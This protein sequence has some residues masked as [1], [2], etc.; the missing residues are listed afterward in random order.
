MLTIGIFMSICY[1]ILAHSDLLLV[2]EQIKMLDSPSSCFLIHIDAKSRE[3]LPDYVLTKENV[4]FADERFDIVW[5]DIS[6]VEAVMKCACQALKNF[7]EADY[8]ILLSGNCFPVKTADYIC[9]YIHDSGFANFITSFRIPSDDCAWLEGG[10]RRL[11]CYAVRVNQRDIATIEP[12][13]INCGNMRQFG[14]IITYCNLKAF[15]K[16]LRILI[17]ANKRSFPAQIQAYGGEFWWRLNRISIEKIMEYY[18]SNEI[19]REEMIYTSIPDEIV[20]P[21]LVNSLCTN[22][23][24]INLTFVN[25]GGAKI[26]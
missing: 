24:N 20:F 3:K 21:T 1:I 10:R 8:F 12:G 2:A 14:K 4:R 26:A 9:K 18:Y 19:F 15:F 6:M 22:V 13:K 25:W 5:G 7:T 17:F 11:N 23:K 16:A